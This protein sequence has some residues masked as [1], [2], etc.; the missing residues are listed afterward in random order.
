MTSRDPRRCCEA[1]WSAMLAT[2]WLLAF[3]FFILFTARKHYSAL[4]AIARTSARPSVDHSKTAEIRIVKFSPYGSPI[5]L[6]FLQ[7]KFRPEIPAGSPERGRPI[8]EGWENEL[9]LDLHDSISKTVRDT[10][11]VTVND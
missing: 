1:V 9:F 2:A 3:I 4:Y 6:H 8:M 7:G 10:S 11:K 5:Y